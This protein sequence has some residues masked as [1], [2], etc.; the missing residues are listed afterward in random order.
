M[1]GTALVCRAAEVLALPPRSERRRTGAELFRHVLPIPKHCVSLKQ[2]INNNL[3]LRSL[4]ARSPSAFAG[5]GD[6]NSQKVSA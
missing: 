4:R 3:K 2:C 6:E 1:Y 5:T